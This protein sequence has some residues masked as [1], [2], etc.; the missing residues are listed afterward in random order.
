M[1]MEGGVDVKRLL[2]VCLLAGLACAGLAICDSAPAG[3]T[4]AAPLAST[5]SVKV[6]PPGRFTALEVCGF[7]MRKAYEWDH[8]AQLIFVTSRPI[9]FGFDGRSS[10]WGFR[11]ISGDGKR[12]A[13]FSVNMAHPDSPVRVTKN[14]KRPPTC[15]DIVDRLKW[16][17]DS[18]EVWKT[19]RRSGPDAWL[20][21]HPLFD[22]SYSGNRFE[23][24]AT[25]RDGP[26]WLVSCTA[27]RLLTPKKYDRIVFCISAVDGHLLS[28]TTSP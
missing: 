28:R 17:T 9:D 25:K 11:C 16:E 23:L 13:A 21:A 5:Q 1:G 3:D 18:P 4:P 20:A 22:L 6:K 2:S 27:K 24:A 8:G 14:V 12:I 15:L 10:R 7:A 19:A 26:Y